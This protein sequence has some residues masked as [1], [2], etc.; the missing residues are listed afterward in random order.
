MAAHEAVQISPGGHV[1]SVAGSATRAWSICTHWAASE[2]L[3]A[4][5]ASAKAQ[6]ERNGEG[7]F[8]AA[9]VE[10]YVAEAHAFA[11]KPPKGVEMATRRNGDVLLYDQASN[12]FGVYTAEGRP[13]TLF[14]PRNG[15]GLLG[16]SKR[17]R[18]E[19]QARARLRTAGDKGQP[20]KLDS[21]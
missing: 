21:G 13:R 7:A 6:F 17:R 18:P 20:P 16:C 9:S 3:A 15:A 4:A 12:V 8:S 14:K 19:Q 11:K 2:N 10:D 1:G 5:E